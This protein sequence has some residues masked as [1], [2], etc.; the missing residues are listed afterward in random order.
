MSSRQWRGGGG[1]SSGA[2]VS[3]ISRPHTLQRYLT[4]TLRSSPA[5]GGVDMGAEKLRQQA[6]A[7]FPQDHADDQTSDEPEDCG[8]G[9]HH[10]QAI[11]EV[12]RPPGRCGPS[13]RVHLWGRFD[14]LASR[15]ASPAAG[16]VRSTLRCRIEVGCDAAT[17]THVL[18][19]ARCRALKCCPAR[20]GASSP[21]SVS[22]R[23]PSGRTD[24]RRACTLSLPPTRPVRLRS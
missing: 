24:V 5:G 7:A 3:L 12:M 20:G 9:R 4:F 13:T 1:S 16:P 21:H 15:R 2:S 23:R 14:V 17:P 19:A 10:P 6:S 18:H 22:R 11:R 8:Q